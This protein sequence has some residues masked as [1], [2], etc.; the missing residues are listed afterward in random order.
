MANLP[1]TNFQMRANLPTLEAN[2][3]EKKPWISTSDDVESEITIHDG[4]PYANGNIHVGHAYNKIIKDILKRY[5]EYKTNKTVNFICG[6]DCHGLPIELAANKEQFPLSESTDLSVYRNYASKQIE[7]QKS[8]FHKL[9]II[10]NHQYETMSDS[11]ED[12]EFK[13]FQQ[14]VKNDLITVNKKPVHW[15]WSC[16]TSLAESELG[17][18][19]ITEK[20]VYVF[21]ESVQEPHLS[22]L[23]WTT[24]PWTLKANTSIAI[25]K[26][27]QYV[28][29]TL[30]EVNR[31]VIV[32]EWFASKVLKLESSQYQIISAINFIGTKFLNPFGDDKIERTI[33]H[34]D[35]VA[36]NV[37]TGLVHIAPSCGKEDY[38]AYCNEFGK[39]QQESY[40]DSTGKITNTDGSVI[41]FKKANKVFIEELESKGKVWKT[42]QASHSYPHCWRCNNPTIQR[43]TEQ[44]FIDYESK[45]DLIL[46]E[47]EK[48]S[49]YPAKAKNR[50]LSFILSRTEWCISRQRKWGVP[51]PTFKC[52]KCKSNLQFDLYVQSVKQWRFDKY[53]P[54]CQ[55]C[56]SSS[57]ENIK[58]GTDILDVWFDSGLTYK[59]LKNKKSDWVVEGSDQHRG[60]FQSSHILS[61]LLEGKTCLTN[62]ISHGFVLDEQGKK[63]SKSAGNVIDPLDVASKRGIEIL[64]L[65]AFSQNVGDDVTIGNSTLEIQ[66][67]NYRK[68]RNTL[69]YLH[70]NLYDFCEE[71]NKKIEINNEEFIKIK[72]LELEFDKTMS[73]VKFSKF[74]FSLMTYL[75][76]FSSGYINN[77]KEKL[78]ESEANSLERRQIQKTYHFVLSSLMKMLNVLLPFTIYE[79]SEFLKT[80]KYTTNSKI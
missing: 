78:Y 60:W 65:W 80:E 72:N 31:T 8:Q 75:E 55:N 41:F 46:K 18:E 59:I 24:T 32:S 69:R 57:E 7:K 51:I 11:F 62:V 71:E 13:A 37:G 34:A 52:L 50:F 26:D 76:D 4:P 1:K 27:L 56:G 53:F 3:L 30:P 15:C 49:F 17:Y 22:F 73:D 10:V 38:I 12:E 45:K 2:I 19:N 9:G 29:V 20:S 36:E 25:N 35:Y 61:C 33:F 14:L 58:K 74:L 47:T 40:T 70:G 6:W 43:A 21:F 42:E 77:S 44:V 54:T 66:C 79:L 63:M 68:I 64:R 16:E 67:N 39:P 48:V 28:V 5:L 23:V